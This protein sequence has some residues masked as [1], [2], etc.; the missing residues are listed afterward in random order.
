MPSST[1][2]NPPL[3]HLLRRVAIAGNALYFLWIFYNGV[4]SGFAARGVR[5]VSYIGIL[6]LLIFNVALFISYREH[7]TGSP[8]SESGDST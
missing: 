6:A 3:R 8:S 1:M 7:D 2:S 5:L 4:A